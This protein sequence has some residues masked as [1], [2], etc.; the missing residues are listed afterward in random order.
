MMCMNSDFI[1][2]PYSVPCT[3]TNKISLNN[4]NGWREYQP[5]AQKAGAAEVRTN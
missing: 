2:H 3:D 5:I 4:N 1:G